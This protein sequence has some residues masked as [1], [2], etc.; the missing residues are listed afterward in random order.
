MLQATGN[1]KSKN[2]QTQKLCPLTIK[3]TRAKTHILGSCNSLPF[4]LQFNHFSKIYY[5]SCCCLVTKSCLTLC[6]P[7][8]C[9]LPGSS[10]HGI[11]QAR[12]V[13]W[14]ATFFSRGSSWPRH[15]TQVSCISRWIL[16]HW[17]SREY[18]SAIKRS[19]TVSFSETR[20]D[21][22]TVMQSEVKSEIAWNLV[23]W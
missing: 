5:I 16:Y 19:K 20:M 21:P 8:D 12:I 6:Y 1:T 13:E 3:A 11:S 9:S 18:Y 2:W 22:E 17:T 15:W 23:K 7:M 10:V 14:V 4:V